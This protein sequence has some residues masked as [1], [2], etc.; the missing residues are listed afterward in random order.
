MSTTV[1]YLEMRRYEVLC[2]EV[3]SLD[4]RCYQVVRTGNKGVPLSLEVQPGA[5]L[6]VV[7]YHT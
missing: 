6:L 5:I 3:P 4:D 7:L 1:L 2:D